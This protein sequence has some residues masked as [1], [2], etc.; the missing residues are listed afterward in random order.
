MDTVLECYFD[1]LYDPTLTELLRSARDLT[2]GGLVGFTL[3]LR[4]E[5]LSLGYWRSDRVDSLPRYLE[6]NSSA[7]GLWTLLLA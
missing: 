4:Y 3:E 1:G 5:A 7:D 2:P 6:M